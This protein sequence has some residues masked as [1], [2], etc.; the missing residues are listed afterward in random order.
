MILAEQHGAGRWDD[1]D[2]R[3]LKEAGYAD[4]VDVIDQ[5]FNELIGNNE[6]TAFG[7]QESN[8]PEAWHSTN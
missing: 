7:M 6:L 1:D 3:D 8:L 2:H 4:V 5:E